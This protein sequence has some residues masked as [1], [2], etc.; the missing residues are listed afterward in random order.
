[1]APR[2]L[3]ALL[4]AAVLTA[5][6][7]QGQDEP[8]PYSDEEDERRGQDGLRT[9]PRRSDPYRERPDEVAVEVADRDI[10]LA[11][12]DDPNVGVAGELVA[13]VMLLD[14]SRGALVE[15]RLHLGLRFTWEFGRLFWD[16]TLREALFA[17]LGWGYTLL[18]EGTPRV[19]VDTHY[20]AFT[21]APAYEFQ[22]GPESDL[23]IFVQAGAGLGYQYTVANH[24][25][26]QTLIAGVKPVLQYGLGFRGRPR[27]RV[28]G[29]MR[30]SFRVELT[31][32][33]RGYMDDTLI[34]GSLG[35]AY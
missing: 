8:I 2:I 10:A 6:P 23:G 31:R 7:A 14:S 12:E 35:I 18:R 21:I 33:R 4:L 22:L 19:Y 28:D 25:G 9:L 32:F 26:N 30:V 29:D 1:M 5:L 20:H 11:G 17:D 27:L 16:E 3:Q 15:P 34:A 13:G 24:D